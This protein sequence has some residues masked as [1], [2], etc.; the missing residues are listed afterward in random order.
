M[1]KIDVIQTNPNKTI[2]LTEREKKAINALIKFR[3]SKDTYRQAAQYLGVKQNTLWSI[4]YRVKL[5]YIRAKE[6]SRECERLQTQLGPR[7]HFITG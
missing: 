7:K 2:P 4:M 3:D 6:F 5:R 1:P